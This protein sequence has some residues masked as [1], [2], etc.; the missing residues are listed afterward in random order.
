[1][2]SKTRR[3]AVLSA[4]IA[5]LTLFGAHGPGAAAE[6]DQSDSVIQPAVLVADLGEAPE[7]TASGQLNAGSGPLFFSQPVIQPLPE[8]DPKPEPGGASSLDQLVRMMASNE[9]VSGDL[10]CLAQAIYFEARGEPLAGQLAVGEVI[11]NRAASPQFP[12]GYCSVVRQRAQFSF[13]KNGRI[14]E[15]RNGSAAWSRAKAVARIAHEGLWDSEAGG[16]LFFHATYV[17]PR[18][19]SQKLALATIDRHIFYR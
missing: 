11:V 4:A 8:P 17:Q 5:S 10:R 12:S 14:P 16:A 18:W 9:P 1:M 15:A 13:V 3:T 2:R 19:A 6:I 7:Q